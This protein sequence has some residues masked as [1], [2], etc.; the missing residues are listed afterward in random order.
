[1]IERVSKDLTAKFGKGFSERSIWKFKQFYIAFQDSADTVGR[2]QNIGWSHIVRIMNLKD[3]DEQKFYLIET[4]REKR[5]LREL[6]RQIN[7]ALYQRLAL[8]KDKDKVMALSK[9]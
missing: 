4:S 6:D 5:S 3:T 7:S 2:I 1:M 9:E 8:S